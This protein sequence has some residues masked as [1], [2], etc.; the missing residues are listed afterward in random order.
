MEEHIN[1]NVLLQNCVNVKTLQIDSKPSI[2][3]EPYHSV[4]SKYSARTIQGH[5]VPPVSS[6]SLQS[7][8]TLTPSQTINVYQML[9]K[10]FIQ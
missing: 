4:L 6:N 2:P 3:K 7:K 9:E 10:N 5:P 8:Q 1:P